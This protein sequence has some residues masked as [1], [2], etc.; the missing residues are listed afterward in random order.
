MNEYLAEFW[1]DF[2]KPENMIGHLAY[3]LLIAS[4]MMRNINWLRALAI[5]AGSISAV[6]YWSLDD[7][8]S[9]FWEA[10]FTLVNVAQLLILQIENR[11]GSFSEEEKYFIQTCLPNIE[12]SHARRLMKLGAWTEVQEDTVLIV[13]DTTPEKLK[14]IVSG[15]AAVT[16]SDR[17]IGEVHKGDFLGEM[18]YLTGKHASATA[19]TLETVR[20]LAFDR[21]RLREYLS[22]NMEVRH[23]LEA[24]FNRNLADKLVKSNTGE[25]KNSPSNSA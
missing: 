13:E 11:R 18:S 6:Y 20:Y 24:S 10:L 14:F 8:V 16:Y 23:A 19:T 12:R 4:M 25:M 22:K 21:D 7:K 3:V 2:S 9:M 5:M 1:V 17:Q 15:K